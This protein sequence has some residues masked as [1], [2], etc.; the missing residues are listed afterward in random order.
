MAANNEVT[1]ICRK[2]TINAISKY[3]VLT[4]RTMLRSILIIACIT[5]QFLSANA[6]RCHQCNSHLDKGCISLPSNT[7][8]QQGDEQ[9]LK[10]CEGEHKAHAFCR[11]TVIKIEVSGEHR[12]IRSCGWKYDRVYMANDGC[13]NADNEGYTQII[14]ACKTDACNAGHSMVASG[15]SLLVATAVCL[16][17]AAASTI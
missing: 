12:I 17:L 10:E 3:T 1:R 16:L 4:S 14:C 11:K 6:I 15:W 2:I 5:S 8:L 7:S 9:Y 13:F